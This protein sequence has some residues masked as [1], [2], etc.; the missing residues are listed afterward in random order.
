MKKFS[1][2]IL[3]KPGNL[4]FFYSDFFKK[5]IPKNPEPEGFHYGFVV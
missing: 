2:R 3:K 1:V 5:K 4:W